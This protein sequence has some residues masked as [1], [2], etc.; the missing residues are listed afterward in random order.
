METAPIHEEPQVEPMS[1]GIF[2][3]FDPLIELTNDFTEFLLLMHRKRWDSWDAFV[4]NQ[5]AEALGL[6]QGFEELLVLTHLAEH[7]RQNGVIPYPHQIETVRKV[8]SQMR[9]RAILAD[10]VGLGKTIEAGMILKEYLL[11]GLVK[12]F[13]ILTPA[14][15]CRQW[16]AELR[17][18]FAIPVLIARREYDWNHYDFLLASMDTAK[19][20][21]HRTEILKGY[22]DMIIVDEAHKLKSTVT[23]NFQFVQGIQKKFFLLLTATPLQNDLKE[24]FNLITLL[25][26]GQLGN[27]RQ[28]KQKF[29]KDKRTPQNA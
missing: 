27:Y 26:P 19:K 9:G 4:L 25:R 15:L 14:A 17:E 1:Y 11:R 28:F 18:K 3:D 29:T 23:Q 20:E 16:E 21:S 2:P 10:E 6:S 22:F 5:R 13:L 8:I 7:W 12:R 24:L